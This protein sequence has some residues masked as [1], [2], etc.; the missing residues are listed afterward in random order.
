MLVARVR[1]VPASSE[2]RSMVE[3]L[4]KARRAANLTSSES[5]YPGID[6]SPN[7]P[8]YMLNILHLSRNAG[9]GEHLPTTRK[10][11]TDAGVQTLSA[12]ALRRTS[13]RIL[14]LN[15]LKKGKAEQ[16]PTVT[17]QEPLLNFTARI[18]PKPTDGCSR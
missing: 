13:T 6:K 9:L 15:H 10:L 1:M 18:R 12:L 8:F 17:Q 3:I 14:Y 2:V 7:P 16:H 4:W 11:S 5:T